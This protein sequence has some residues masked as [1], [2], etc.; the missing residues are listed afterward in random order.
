MPSTRAL[1]IGGEGLT[2][3]NGVIEDV[4][5]YNRVLSA[6]EVSELYQ[7]FALGIISVPTITITGS[8]NQTYSIQYVTN[9]SSTNW[10]TLVSHILLQGNTYLYPDTNS[11]GQSQRFYQVVAQ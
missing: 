2:Y 4:R 7:G 1:Y 8:T 6:Q 5:I 3:F 9:L 11:V 10:T